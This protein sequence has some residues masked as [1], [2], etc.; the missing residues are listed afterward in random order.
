MDDLQDA[1]SRLM[2]GVRPVAAAVEVAGLS[3]PDAGLGVGPDD[4][5]WLL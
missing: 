5:G 3:D 2:L 4:V 1:G